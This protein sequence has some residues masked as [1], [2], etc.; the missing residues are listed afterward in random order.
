MASTAT[1][2]PSFQECSPHHLMLLL[3]VECLPRIH[4]FFSCVVTSVASCDEIAAGDLSLLVFAGVRM[5]H[6][7]TGMHGGSRCLTLP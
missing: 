4:G 3:G 2:N 5:V 6:G 7:L 1:S